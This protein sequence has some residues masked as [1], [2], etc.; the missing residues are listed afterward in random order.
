MLKQPDESVQEV[1][2]VVL[3]LLPSAGAPRGFRL[4]HRSEIFQLIK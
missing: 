2:A 1:W 4:K 3:T